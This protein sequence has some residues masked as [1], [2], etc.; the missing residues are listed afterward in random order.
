MEGAPDRWNDLSKGAEAGTNKLY[1]GNN[2][3]GLWLVQ[4]FTL[5]VT[6][7]WGWRARAGP[8]EEGLEGQAEGLFSRQKEKSS[9]RI[10][11][12]GWHDPGGILEK[13]IQHQCVGGKTESR[14]LV[15]YSNTHMGLIRAGRWLL[16]LFS[17]WSLLQPPTFYTL[18]WLTLSLRSWLKRL[19]F[20]GDFPGRFPIWQGPSAVCSHRRPLAL[21]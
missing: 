18:P 1:S 12:G 13:L 17:V 6:E 5:R 14:K 21:S 11:L 2:D 15:D 16:N 20:Q 9:G 7:V 10:T 4:G 3:R 19:F 8:G